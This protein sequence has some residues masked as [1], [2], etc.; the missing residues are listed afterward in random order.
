[1]E[2]VKV[3]GGVWRL[4][5]QPHSKRLLLAAC[6]N[7]GAKIVEA[8]HSLDRNSVV[9]EFYGHSSIVYGADWCHILSQDISEHLSLIH[10]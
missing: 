5:L 2:V 3:G 10:I 1:M 6:M 8:E 9:S 4:K 7:G